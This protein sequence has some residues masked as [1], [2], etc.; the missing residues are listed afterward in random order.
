MDISDEKRRKA[1]ERIF[2]HDILNTAGGIRGLAE[3]LHEASPQEVTQYKDIIYSLAHMIVEEINSQRTLSSA[4]NGELSAN[5]STVATLHLLKEVVEVF[6]NY[7]TAHSRK[8]V[9]DDNAFD[10]ELFTDRALLQRVLGN[11]LKNGLEA[12]EPGESVTIGCNKTE[13]GV[14]FWVHNPCEMP[15]EIQ[16]QIF[17]R[18]FSTKGTGKRAWHLQHKVIERTLLERHC[19]FQLFGRRDHFPCKPTKP[20]IIAITAITPSS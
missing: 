18:S 8:L 20:Q 19:I 2:F 9:I 17:Q 10:T 12:S 3:L 11:M 16:L 7:D 13:M 15:R 1:L 6:K 4:E 14:E 5:P